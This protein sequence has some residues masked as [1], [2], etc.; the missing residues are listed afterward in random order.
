M[1]TDYS[2]L[3]FNFA[4]LHKPIIYTH[5]DYEEYRNKQYQ[6]GFFDYIKNGFCPVCF[7]LDCTINS[8]IIKLK[9]NC[10]NEIKYLKRINKLFLF[11]DDKNSE[12][13]YLNL[14]KCSNDYKNVNTDNRFSKYILLNQFIILLIKIINNYFLI[15][16]NNIY[17]I[18]IL[19]LEIFLN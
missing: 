9:N 11:K 16:K 8:I 2:N 18:Y 5:F 13:L 19:N 7:N 6:K 3:F 12:R 14:I 1:I 4:Y 10:T 15:C 17:T